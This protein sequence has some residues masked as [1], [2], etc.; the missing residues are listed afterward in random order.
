MNLD[1]ALEEDGKEWRRITVPLG[2]TAHIGS[3]IVSLIDE[4]RAAKPEEPMVDRVVIRFLKEGDNA[5]KG[6][7]R[8]AG[9]IGNAAAP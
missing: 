4:Y 7:K 3:A 6:G 9:V 5:P 8:L 1:L 2:S